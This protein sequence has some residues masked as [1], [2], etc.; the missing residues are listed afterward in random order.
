MRIKITQPGIYGNDGEIAVGTEFTVK[1]GPKGWAGRYEVISGGDEGEPHIINPEM[2]EVN[3]GDT[4]ENPKTGE[5]VPDGQNSG[6]ST[7]AV[8][9]KGSGWYAVT[10]GEKEVT[11]SLRKDALD[12][13]N[14]LTDDEKRAFVEANKPE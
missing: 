11:K 2:G 6:K 10:D 7:Y 13:F 4:T 9:D 1:D 3:I 5:G 12:G 8:K 14:G